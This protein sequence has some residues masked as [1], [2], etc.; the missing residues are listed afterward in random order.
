[1][2]AGN[3]EA[4]MILRAVE[5]VANWSINE[6]PCDVDEFG[7]GWL[8]VGL[9]AQSEKSHCA[10]VENSKESASAFFL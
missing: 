8:V 3:A 10:R 4:R 9:T 6:N 5:R 7:S 2:D 1:M